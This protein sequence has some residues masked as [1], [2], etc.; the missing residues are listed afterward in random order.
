MTAIQKLQFQQRALRNYRR[1]IKRLS[2]FLDPS[3]VISAM[4]TAD[5][6]EAKVRARWGVRFGGF[7]R[8]VNGR[9]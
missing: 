4:Q 7:L 8:R 6:L 5:R 9:I 2:P 3:R 1:R